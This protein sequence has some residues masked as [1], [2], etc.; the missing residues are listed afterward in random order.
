MPTIENF[1]E[2]ITKCND[3]ITTIQKRKSLLSS[4]LLKLSPYQA[5][6]KVLIES[7]EGRHNAPSFEKEAFIRY[8]GVDR[9][10]LFKYKFSKVKKDG[11]QSSVEYYDFYVERIIKKID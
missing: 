4:E 10:G 7:N 9:N 5:G 1:I 6:D 3:E 8:A 11:S 2:N